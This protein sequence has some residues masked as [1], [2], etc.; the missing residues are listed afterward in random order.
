V[1]GGLLACF[2]IGGITGALGF[3]LV[4]Y[5]FTI[6]I[7]LLLAVMALVPAI[8]DLQLSDRPRR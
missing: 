7:A 2:L 5:A 6:P 4:G 3:K 8:D 1:L